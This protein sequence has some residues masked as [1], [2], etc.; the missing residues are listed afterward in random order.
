[1][2]LPSDLALRLAIAGGVRARVT[3]PIAGFELF[4]RRLDG[5]PLGVMTTAQVHF[6]PLAWQLASRDHSLLDIQRWADVTEWLESP[7]EEETGFRDVCGALPVVV[8]PRY[9]VQ[10]QLWTELLSS[11][12]TFIV[13]SDDVS[14]G[15]RQ[16]SA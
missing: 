3:G 16:R 5:K 15:F 13:H 10:G 7:A 6:P 11:E 8:L 14:P 4:G 9:D 12:T 2:T 1:M